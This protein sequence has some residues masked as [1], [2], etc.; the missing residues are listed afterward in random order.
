MTQEEV[1]SIAMKTNTMYC[2][3]DPFP[4]NLIKFNLDILISIITDLVNKSLT[5]REFLKDE[6]DL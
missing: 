2:D 5:S 4:T 1:H 3:S 6:K